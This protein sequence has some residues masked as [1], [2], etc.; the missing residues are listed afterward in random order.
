MIRAVSPK[1]VA[2]F[3]RRL[4]SSKPS[5]AAFGDGAD[6]VNYDALVKRYDNRN[7]QGFGVLRPGFLDGRSRGLEQQGR[8]QLV[9]G[10][11]ERLKQ[12]VLGGGPD[13]APAYSS[14]GSSS[15]SS[16]GSGRSGSSKSGSS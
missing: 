3:M 1:A 4:L 13:K 10:V 15:S 16:D 9:H 8:G 2:D 5:L 7:S 11:L 6:A 14:S 12:G